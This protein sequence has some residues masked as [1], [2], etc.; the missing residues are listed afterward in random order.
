MSSE[1]RD[2]YDKL[3]LAPR[4]SAGDKQQPRGTLIRRPVD[5][6]VDPGGM[7]DRCSPVG[8]RASVREDRTERRLS[9]P[10]PRMF[11]SLR[12]VCRQRGRAHSKRSRAEPRRVA[13]SAFQPRRCL[14]SS[15]TVQ[16]GEGRRM[17]LAHRS[18]IQRSSSAVSHGFRLQS[19]HPEY[20]SEEVSSSESRT[21]VELRTQWQRLFV[22]GVV[23]ENIRVR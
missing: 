16:V 4:A 17:R 23:N 14:G 21:A 2:S 5:H 6:V 13:E 18:P 15:G 3:S 20:F 1:H 11:R 19:P 8:G 22:A 10:M 9:R 12:R 7:A